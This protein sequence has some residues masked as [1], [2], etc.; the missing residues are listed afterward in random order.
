M[1][2]ELAV[3]EAVA[4]W[5][6]DT[7][8]DWED[9]LRR[10]GAHAPRGRHARPALAGVAAVLA[11]VLA[12]PGLG[13]QKRLTSLLA[14]DSKRPGLSLGTTLVRTDGTRAGTFTVQ[15]SRL[16]VHVGGGGRPFTNVG[17]PVRWTLAL[18]TQASSARVVA[19]ETGKTLVRLCAPCPQGTTNGRS[20]LPRGAFSLLFGRADVVVSTSQGAARG[21]IRLKRPARR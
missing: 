18:S 8:P 12:L 15:S 16:F 2:I 17:F 14:G 4:E 11:L 21:R 13:V 10:T 19:R 20:R 3:R 9:V 6:P 5:R 7:P 1:S